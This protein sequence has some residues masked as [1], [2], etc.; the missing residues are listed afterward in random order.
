[1]SHPN[2]NNNN[3]AMQQ[4]MTAQ[5]QLIQMMS[6][7]IANTMNPQELQEID[8]EKP[9]EEMDTSLKAC[10]ACGEI[11]HLAKEC[12][13]EWPHSTK[14]YPTQVTCFLC[15]GNNHVPFQCQLYPRVLHVSQ[16][17]KEEMLGALKKA[18]EDQGSSRK[19]KLDI[20]PKEPLASSKVTTKCCYSCEGEGHL[21]RNCPNK[22]PRSPTNVVEYHG[23]EYEAMMANLTP[24]KRKKDQEGRD[25]S[26]VF[27]YFCRETG[28]FKDSCP[29]KK[30]K[31]KNV[32]C[33]RCKNQGHYAN[34]CPERKNVT[35]KP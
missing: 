25:M 21:S 18:S 20:S 5:A 8:M 13:D 10:K 34:K 12:P 14:A 30:K 35:P 19:H 17:A 23:K 28:H 7:Y 27:C 1:M 4:L 16:K 26:V 32:T 24:M 9:S 11:G 22:K 29:E 3:D 6:Q 15:E 2:A 31:W 33:F